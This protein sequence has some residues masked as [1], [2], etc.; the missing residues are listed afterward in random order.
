MTNF[1]STKMTRSSFFKK[2]HFPVAKFIELTE[3][4]TIGVQTGAASILIK[5][6]LGASGNKKHRQL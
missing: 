1:P 5:A 6:S 2:K 4:G 3:S